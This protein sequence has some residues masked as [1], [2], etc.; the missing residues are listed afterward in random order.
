MAH[1]G[2]RDGAGRGADEG[3]QMERGKVKDR[4]EEKA[5]GMYG[6][7]AGGEKANT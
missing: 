3:R 2:K 7:D 4:H 5:G 1:G 6:R